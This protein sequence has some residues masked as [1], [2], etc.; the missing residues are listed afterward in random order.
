[1]YK[2]KLIP[3]FLILVSFFLFGIILSPTPLLATEEQDVINAVK[4]V[5][6]SVVNI[7]VSRKSGGESIGSGIIMTSDGWIITNAHVVRGADTITVTLNNGKKYRTK[8]YKASPDTDI[9][10]VKIQETGLPYAN[11]GDSDRLQQGQT[12]IAIGNPMRFSSTVTVGV[13]SALGRDIKARGIV[14]HNL[15]QTDA[16]INPGNS[17]GALVDSKGRV[18]GINTLVYTGNYQYS[19]AQGL[20]FAI[21][22]NDALVTARNLSRAGSQGKNKPWIGISGKD[23]TREDAE[24]HDLSVKSG[25]IIDSVMPNSPAAKAKLQ[26]GDIITEFNG[27]PVRNVAEFKALLMSAKPYST[28]TLGV[29]RQNKKSTVT[30]TVEEISQ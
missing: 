28:V 12:A 20:S 7:T 24:A 19:N 6:P 10:V 27:K 22:I 29:W 30:I 1:M 11:F 23:L 4:K 5:S 18:I 21:P 17:G 25:V 16:A 26:A 14:Y 3:F 2:H 8:S 13:I 9:A 15:I